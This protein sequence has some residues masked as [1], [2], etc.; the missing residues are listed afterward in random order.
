MY[1]Q[2]NAGVNVSRGGAGGS[3]GREPPNVDQVSVEPTRLPTEV[4]SR[5]V[6]MVWEWPEIERTEMPS[7]WTADGKSARAMMPPKLAAE[8]W[9][10]SRSEPKQESVVRAL[11][12][13]PVPVLTPTPAPPT[14]TIPPT[15]V[16]PTGGQWVLN[17]P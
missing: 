17:T 7:G 10:M 11:V 4:G 16:G 15:V 5:D 12:S 1:E 8:S 6:V 14:P 13:T 2:G 9:R 3:V